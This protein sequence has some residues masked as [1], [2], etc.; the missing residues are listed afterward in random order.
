VESNSLFTPEISAY[1]RSRQWPKGFKSLIVERIQ[2]QTG[3]PYLQFVTYVDNLRSFDG[4]DQ[5]QIAMMV[6]EFMEKVRKM[7]VPIY[8][9]IRE[10]DGR[11]ETTG[12]RVGSRG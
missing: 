6:K 11:A 1:Y 12:V 7:G 9:E 8:T 10:G 4:E 5:L 2:A 3:D